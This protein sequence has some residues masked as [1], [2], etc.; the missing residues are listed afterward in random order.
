MKN[1]RQEKGQFIIIAALLISILIVSVSTIMYGTVTYY[2]HERWEE[3]LS[4]IDTLKINS[5]RVV[6]ISLA[7]YTRSPYDNRILRENLH[8]WQSDIRKAYPGLGP[9]LT[10]TL[11]NS[12]IEI[13]YG[14]EDVEVE[15]INGLAIDWYNETSARAFSAANVTFHMNI[16]SVGLTG[17]KFISASFII[18]EILSAVYDA[19]EKSLAVKLS[20]DKEGL[21]PIINLPK[22]SFSLSVKN[23]SGQWLSLDFSLGRYYDSDPSIN[24]F[25][26]ELYKDEL[27]P[28][29]EP[30]AV[31]VT[32]IETRNIKVVANST[33]TQA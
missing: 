12:T 6:E 21:V 24:R 20:L 30:S 9:I 22:D 32:T 11:T 1:L 3:Y 4:L 14:D 17:Y 31:S 7:N 2:R 15:Y 25:V 10:Y 13:E 27:S 18:E 16:T 28:Q 8:Q 29:E 5:R 33:V 23:T 26:Y 19:S